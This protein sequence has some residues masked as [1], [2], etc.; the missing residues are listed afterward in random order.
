MWINQLLLYICFCTP[1]TFDYKN[2]G[3]ADKKLFGIF[4]LSIVLSRNLSLLKPM[5][6]KR[7]E[8][9]ELS[10]LSDLSTKRIE[11]YTARVLGN[12]FKDYG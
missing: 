6:V 9:G 8:K 7:M 10:I 12:F 1:F 3:P 11:H 2:V 5:Y 4:Q